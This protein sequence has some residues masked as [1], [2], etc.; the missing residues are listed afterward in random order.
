L[1]ETITIKIDSERK[2]ELINLAKG[3]GLTLAGYCRMI[4]LEGTHET[5]KAE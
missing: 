4:L 3:K 5:T 1:E 2:E